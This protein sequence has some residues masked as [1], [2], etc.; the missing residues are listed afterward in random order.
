MIAELDS[1]GNR[2]QSDY[3][4]AEQTLR[5][6]HINHTVVVFGSSRTSETSVIQARLVVA[7]DQCRID[8]D[9]KEW[10]NKKRE[11]QNNL[12]QSRYYEMARRLGQ[13][14]GRQWDTR[15]WVTMTGGG[16]GIMEAV[17]RGAADVGAPTVGLN[18][19]LPSEQKPNGYIT[20]ELKISFE[21]FAIRKLHF[22]KRAIAFVVFPGGFGTLDELFGVLTLVQTSKVPPVPVI[23]VGQTFWESV[24]HG[25]SLV[26]AQ[27]ISPKDLSLFTYV[28]SDLEV[29][30]ILLQ[31]CV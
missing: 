10:L 11:A 12:E 19:I 26:Q 23:L 4:R 28:E 24:F 9:N 21:F 15:G 2:L 29:E 27:T 30:Q 14:I 6:H 17:N 31:H 16:G 8:P 1:T 5:L 7:E 13:R 20:P 25:Q 22:H 18:I 3:D